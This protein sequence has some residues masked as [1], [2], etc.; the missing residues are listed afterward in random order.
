MIDVREVVNL[1]SMDWKLFFSIG[2]PIFAASIMAIIGW[3]LKRAITGLEATDQRIEKKVDKIESFS[4]AAASSIVE[5]QTL[6]TG[7]GFTVSQRLAYAPGSP[8]RLTDYGET[9]MKDS[10][11]YEILKNNSA[12][13]VDLVKSKNPSTNYDIQ[14]LSRKVLKELTDSNNTL[15]LPLKNYA[16]NKGLPLE[17]LINTA[18]IVLR[19]EVM[20]DLSFDDKTLDIKK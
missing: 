15:I 11:F 8:T 17:I 12:F 10:G 19:D 14:E 1:H 9:L 13:F 6:L 3:L 7:R 16:Y 5:I 2:V 20:K 4:Q 18:G